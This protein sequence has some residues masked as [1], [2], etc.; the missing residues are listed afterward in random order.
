MS[1]AAQRKEKHGWAIEKPKLDNAR[2]LRGTY[3]TDPGDVEFK[4]TIKNVRKKLEVPMEAGM[5]CKVRNTKCK[6][7]CT[8]PDIWKSTYASGKP[9]TPPGS[10]WRELNTRIT[11]IILQKWDSIS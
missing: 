10:V 4:E 3:F 8:G 6:E 1:K 2:R 9:T 11:K 5:L 7:T